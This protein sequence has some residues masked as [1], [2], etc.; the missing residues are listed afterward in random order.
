MYLI[1]VVVP[2]ALSAET[3]KG[4]ITYIHPAGVFDVGSVHVS[5]SAQ[6][7]C[8]FEDSAI[9]PEINPK[10]TPVQ[11]RNGQASV[12]MFVVLTGEFAKPDTFVATKLEVIR[13]TTLYVPKALSLPLLGM[14]PPEGILIRDPLAEEWPNLPNDSKASATWWIDG[15]PMTINQ[16][17]QLLA[18]RSSELAAGGGYNIN[19]MHLIHFGH[20]GHAIRS[21]KVLGPNMWTLYHYNSASASLNKGVATRIRVWPNTLTAAEKSFLAQ[22]SAKISQPDDTSG[23]PGTIQF[24]QGPPIQTVARGTIQDYVSRVGE[25]VVPKY[26]KQLAVDDPSKINFRFYVVRSFVYDAKTYLVSIDGFIPHTSA[27]KYRYNQPITGKPV[28]A[29]VAVPNGIIMVPDTLCAHLHNEAELAS[30][31]SDSVTS[32][33]QKQGY[34]AWPFTRPQIDQEFG[35]M[36]YLATGEKAALIRIG[37]RQLYLA[38]YDIR[39]AP[40]VFSLEDGL[41]TSNPLATSAQNGA[42]AP[43]YVSYTFSHISEYYKDVDYSKLKRGEAEYQQFLNEL[44]KADPEAF[45]DS[46]H[47]VKP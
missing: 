26:Q 32:V 17:T 9:Q 27:T 40:Y 13:D 34:R 33:V 35:A 30:L 12:G 24:A 29:P 37:M 44:R 10:T 28:T 4:F 6:S 20:L 19:P 21:W 16:Q 1:C 47:P 14:R 25:S 15:Y 18:S 23:D 43:W 38:G 3:I 39:E 11:C 46:A 5:F 7:I 45:S 42:T 8:R 31:L 22:Y 36:Q 41:P 2:T